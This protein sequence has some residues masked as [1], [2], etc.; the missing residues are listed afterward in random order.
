MTSDELLCIGGCCD[1]LRTSL[2][3]S[4]EEIQLCKTIRPST[5]TWSASVRL[6]DAVNPVAS[7]TYVRRRIA[8]KQLLAVHSLSVEDIIDLLFSNY[9]RKLNLG[10]SIT[11]NR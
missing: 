4:R 6:C 10:P 7:D 11:D 2:H 5:K 1:G 9:G 3:E 8:G